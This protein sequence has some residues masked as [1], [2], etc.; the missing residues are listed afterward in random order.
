MGSYKDFGFGDSADRSVVKIKGLSNLLL[1]VSACGVGLGDGAVSIRYGCKYG[2]R[3][4]PRAAV[5]ACL[6]CCLQA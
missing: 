5:K 6:P 2:K 4:C 3:C 1:A